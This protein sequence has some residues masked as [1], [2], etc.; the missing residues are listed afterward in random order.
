MFY[1]LA[2]L[3]ACSFGKEIIRLFLS[4][5]T[6]LTQRIKIG[7]TLSDWKNVL[8]GV[9]QGSILASLFFNIFIIDLFFFSPKSEFCN[10]ADNSSLYSCGMNLDNNLDNIL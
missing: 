5:L 9:S 7:S 4:Y 6:N 2:K 8:K 3:Q 10:F 1:L